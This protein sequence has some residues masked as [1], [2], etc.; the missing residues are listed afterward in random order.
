MAK[1]SKSL[2]YNVK[3]EGV[4]K[5]NK[6]ELLQLGL[7]EEQANKV[8]ENNTEQLKGF[9]P[10][11]RFDEVNNANKNLKEQL[12][13]RDSQLEE[14]KKNNKDNKELQETIQKL[15]ED[16]KNLTEK[17]NN[18]LSKIKLDNAIEIALKDSNALN[19]KAVKALLDLEKVEFKEEKLVGLVEQIEA[20]KTAEDSKMLFKSTEQKTTFTGVQPGVGNTSN[21]Q[22]TPTIFS[23][24]QNLYGAK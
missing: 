14:L 7:T 20:L 17:H 9:I 4:I 13:E 10:K 12:T 6:E 8:L 19:S 18:E 2:P 5:L 3:N 24:L 21:Q 22:A 11:A 1:H 15:Q 23:A 16:N